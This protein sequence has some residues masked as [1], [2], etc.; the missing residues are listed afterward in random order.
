MSYPLTYLPFVKS[1]DPFLPKARR[2]ASRVGASPSVTNRARGGGSWRGIQVASFPPGYCEGE[3]QPRTADTLH[4]TLAG[5]GRLM[6]N[7]DVCQIEAGV[8]FGAPAGTAYAIANTSATEELVLFVAEVAVPEN[9][10]EYPPSYC[11]L[12][13]EL[14][15]SDHFHPV[16]SG[17]RRI[18]PEVAVVHLRHAFAGPWG[19]LSLLIVP[20]ASRV[21][22][23][24][25]PDQDQVL[26]VMRG[27]ATFVFSK[28]ASITEPNVREGAPQVELANPFH[29]GVFVPRGKPCGFM[30]QPSNL[31]PLF[32]ACLTVS[33][34]TI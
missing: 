14:H 23:Y 34:T 13:R 3:P 29:Q 28:G 33:H 2:N 32:I 1:H 5:Q 20:P 10:L 21:E 9:A 6:S 31:A 18:R 4:F 16:W 22:P 12:A 26:V 8:M 15:P 7:G 11:H 27:N 25:E 30:N 19:R 24:S 17:S